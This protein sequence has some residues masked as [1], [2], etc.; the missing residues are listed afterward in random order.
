MKEPDAHGEHDV[1]APLAEIERFQPGD[2]ELRRPRLDIRSVAPRRSVDHLRRA[3]DGRE[4]PAVKQLAYERRRDTM[5]APDLEHPVIGLDPQPVH[6]RP[7]PLAH[8]PMMAAPALA[9][10]GAALNEPRC[11]TRPMPTTR[12]RYTVT[13]TAEVSE[14]LDFAHR[15][16]PEVTDRK[17][18]LLRLAATGRDALRQQL[19]DDDRVRRRAEQIEAMQRAATLLDVDLLLADAAWQ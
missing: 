13:D 10:G 14:M 5:P 15:A 18:L 2:E 4:P 17:Q 3:V 11:Y 19:D 8:N 16:W 1:E 9:S 6:H 7:Q 12:P